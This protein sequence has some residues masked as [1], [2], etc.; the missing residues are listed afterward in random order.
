[1]KSGPPPLLALLLVFPLL[2]TVRS[3]CPAGKLLSQSQDLL[4]RLMVR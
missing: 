2:D 3:A 1:M 4:V